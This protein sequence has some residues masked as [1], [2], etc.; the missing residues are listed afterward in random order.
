VYSRAR[1]MKISRKWNYVW[2][3]MRGH[4][5]SSA[6]FPLVRHGLNSPEPTHSCVRAASD[7]Q[8]RPGSAACVAVCL[9]RP[10]IRRATLTCL[11]LRGCVSIPTGL[12]VHHLCSPVAGSI[13]PEFFAPDLSEGVTPRR[14]SRRVFNSPQPARTIRAPRCATCRRA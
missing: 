12:P 6:P 2:T 5:C 10:L 4:A 9:D 13:A 11:R 8:G 14:V 7:G 1:C 3:P